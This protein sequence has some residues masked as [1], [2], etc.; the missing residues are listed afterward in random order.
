[1]TMEFEVHISTSQLLCN[2]VTAHAE[3]RADLDSLETSKGK[4]VH[5]GS[6]GG[7]N[8]CETV[9]TVI[10]FAVLALRDFSNSAEAYGR[11]MG[12]FRAD[13]YRTWRLK[14]LH[15]R[16]KLQTASL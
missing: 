9:R 7:S 11:I 1:M 8:I 6:F 4:A 5:T 13:H 12:L 3:K 15:P 16:Q 10:A 2:L 14:G